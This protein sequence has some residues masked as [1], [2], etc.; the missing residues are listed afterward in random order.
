MRSRDDAE[1]RGE[2]DPAVG[3]TAAAGRGRKY[4][5]ALR[6]R[7]IAWV[8]RAKGG[9]EA[10]DRCSEAIGVPQHRFEMWRER[11]RER[12]PSG[13]AMVPFEV[14]LELSVEPVSQDL[15][16]IEVPRSI[17]MAP[18]MALTTPRGF[19]IEGLTL[20]QAYALLREYE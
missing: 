13:E 6:R 14:P 4:T 9:R 16:P 3:R 10:R 19:A 7:I 2:A 11:E 5:P 17:L 1:R 12:E 18:G 8:A 15:V 20:E